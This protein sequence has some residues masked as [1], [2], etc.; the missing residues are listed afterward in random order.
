MELQRGV[1][2][3]GGAISDLQIWVWALLA[4]SPAFAVAV[5]AWMMVLMMVL[6]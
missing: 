2:V 1:K 3:E 5:Y 4:A 6:S